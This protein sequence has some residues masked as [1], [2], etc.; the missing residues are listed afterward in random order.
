MLK[1]AQ[2]STDGPSRRTSQSVTGKSLGRTT[3]SPH[4]KILQFNNESLED[5]MCENRHVCGR[6]SMVASLRASPM[7]RNTSNRS[8]A[9]V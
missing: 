6:K 2:Q 7:F 8:F 4:S 3:V 9:S 1:T 5:G